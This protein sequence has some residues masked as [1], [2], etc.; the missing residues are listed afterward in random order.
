MSAVACVVC[1]GVGQFR[2]VDGVRDFEYG[3]VPE[4]RMQVHCCA[5]CGSDFLFPR[6]SEGELEAYYPADYHAFHDD[7]GVVAR[8]LVS[9]RGRLR[10]RAY[11]RI[12]GGRDGA[13]FDVGVGDC[14]HFD[15]LR[16]YA[17]IDCSGVEIVPDIAARARARG[18]DVVTGTLETMDIARHI[19]QYDIVSMN[20]VLEHVV[21]PQTLLARAFE[22]LK[23]GGWIIGQLP[24]SSCWEH[25]FFGRVWAGYHFPRHLQAFSQR[26]LRDLLNKN[27]FKDVTIRTA[28]HLQSALS[29]QNA[30][31]AAGWRPPLKF[32]KSPIYNFL[33]LSVMPFEVAAY[34]FDKGG[35]MNFSARAPERST[36]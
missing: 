12:L 2:I 17:R 22:L 4:R 21:A 25:D 8:F 9:V 14:R 16:R 15:A 7:H 30:L 33:L 6:P 34:L 18:Y 13:L 10:A 24:S 28:P 3:V 27:G 35:I 11:S 36:A 26:G 20:H 31:I 1:G 5:A 19:G 32:G 29:V 23:P